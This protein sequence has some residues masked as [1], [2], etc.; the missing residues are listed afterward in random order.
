MFNQIT[1]FVKWHRRRN[2]SARTWRDYKYDLTQFHDFVGA[3]EPQAVTVRDIDGFINHQSERGMSPKTINRRLTA[4]GSFYVYLSDT[5]P[6]ITSPVIP[7]RHNRK[8]KQRLPRPVPMDEVE[9]FFAVIDNLRDMAMFQLMLRCGLRISEVASLKVADIHLNETRPRMVVN[10]KNDIERTVYLTPPSRKMVMGVLA[11]RFSDE[12]ELFLSYQGKAMSTTAIHKR[13]MV[14]RDLAGV[15]FTAHQLRHTFA[16][17]LVEE[18]VPIPTIQKLMGHAWIA[19]T[20][21][22]LLVS[23]SKVAKDFFEAMTEQEVWSCQN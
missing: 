21:G 10:G 17:N 23:D 8:E 5:D 4:I 16:T 19:T 7:R 15:S 11:S 14:Y 2:P 18:D 6:T 9:K 20:Q 13:L 1:E 12:E 3:K 22:Y